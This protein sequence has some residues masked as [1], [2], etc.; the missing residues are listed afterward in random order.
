MSITTRIADVTDDTF[1]EAVLAGQAPILVEFWATWC[2]LCRMVGPVLADLADEHADR[3][4]VVRMDSDAN[5]RTV[6]DLRVLGVPT[7]V[8]FKGG[9]P[10]ASVVGLGASRRCG[11]RSSRTCD[12]RA[13]V[14]R[15]VTSLA[16]GWT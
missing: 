2:G 11:G 14:G 7:M 8:L 3:W 5:P 10:V 9:E 1:A 15:L 12:R 4:R 16:L 6:R 13:T